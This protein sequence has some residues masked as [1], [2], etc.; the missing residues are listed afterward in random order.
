M[1]WGPAIAE[2]SSV[3]DMLYRVRSLL[4]AMGISIMAKYRAPV[5]RVAMGMIKEM[6]A[7]QRQV[8]MIG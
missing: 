7:V 1:I 3:P 4:Q 6:M 8:A 5:L 2:V